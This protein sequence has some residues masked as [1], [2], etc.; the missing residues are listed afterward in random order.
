MKQPEID[1][2]LRI[3]IVG[4]LHRKYKNMISELGIERVVL[5]VGAVSYLESLKYISNA[6]VLLL[7]DAPSVGPSVFLPLKLIEY[8][9]SGNPIF[10]ITPLKGASANLIRKLGGIVT[11]PDDIDGI[12]KSIVTLYEKYKSNQLPDSYLDKA[13]VD[14]YSAMN[15]TKILVELFEKVIAMRSK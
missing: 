10:G 15:T 12:G 2:L 4:D 14:S 3:Q 6:D 11:S 7:I 5:H 8:L 13:L 1:Q 9:G